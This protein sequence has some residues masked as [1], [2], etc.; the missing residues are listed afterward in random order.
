MLHRTS[1][2]LNSDVGE[3]PSALVD[4]SEHQ[5]LRFV[6][7]ANIACGGHAGDAESMKRVVDIC[8]SL[9]VSIG[10]HPSYPDRTGFGRAKIEM[11]GT[12]LAESISEQI[13]SLIVIARHAGATVRHVKPHGALYNTAVKDPELSDT[14]ARA[15]AA[16]DRN[17]VLVG[18][19]GSKMLEV[20]RAAGFIVAGEA[21]ADRR[22][23]SDGAL[24]SRSSEGALITNPDEAVG[25]VL[26]LVRDGEICEADG[27]RFPADAQ[28]VCIHSDTENAIAIAQS[29][30]SGLLGVGI[31]VKPF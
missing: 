10:A 12:P 15:V 8:L 1:I 13:D 4:G 16:I 27:T 14:I 21:F 26:T 2:D 28:T 20:W 23:E 9:G 3:R 24:R 30:R 5:L 31:D 18:L 11:G 6:S 19:A 22:Y 7:S 25:R 29:V 17:L